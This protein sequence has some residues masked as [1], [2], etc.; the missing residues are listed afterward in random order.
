MFWHWGQV[1][2][3]INAIQSGGGGGVERRDASFLNVL[4][5]SWPQAPKDS[6]R[7]MQ[8]QPTSS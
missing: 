6:T 3:A 8:L 4:E 2:S 5:A 1:E 7:G